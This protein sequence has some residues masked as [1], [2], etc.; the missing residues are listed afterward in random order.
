MPATAS[1]GYEVKL[2][3]VLQLMTI[4]RF[5]VRRLVEG[6]TWRMRNHISHKAHQ[7]SLYCI[8]TAAQSPKPR[9]P[10]LNQPVPAFRFAPEV[11]EPVAAIP[12]AVPVEEE[13]VVDEA[14]EFCL[15]TCTSSPF[16]CA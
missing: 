4:M 7:F 1:E 11:S 5:R 15:A 13:A 9:R 12:V 14:V 10:S 2:H 16:C 3:Y 6:I 8:P